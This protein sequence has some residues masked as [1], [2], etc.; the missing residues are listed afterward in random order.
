MNRAAAMRLRQLRTT[1]AV[2][3]FAP[4]EVDQSIRDFCGTADDI[5]IDSSNVVSWLMEQTCLTNQDL[6]GL[7]IAQGLDFCQRRDAMSRYSDHL[8]NTKSRTKLLEVLLEPEH[9]TLDQLYGESSSGLAAAKTLESLHSPHLQA[10]TRQLIQ[11]ESELQSI[12]VEALSEVEQEREVE[13]QLEA[14]RE[15]QKPEVYNALIYP[16]LHPDIKH[17]MQTGILRKSDSSFEH[18]FNYM[19]MTNIGK[20]FGLRDSGSKLFV[21]T[22]FSRTVE[23]SNMNQ[24][25]GDRFLV[26]FLKSFSR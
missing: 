17:F 26:S 2:V 20:K 25:A 22:E 23:L 15:A 18:V 1:Q 5:N 7:Y 19:G 10:F 14:V 21:S 9:Q 8:R 6:H 11:P 3:F 4:P 16:G 12:R 24:S 13:V